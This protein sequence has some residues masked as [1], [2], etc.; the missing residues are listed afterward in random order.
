MD[1][2][3]VP[4]ATKMDALSA[5]AVDR[6]GAFVQLNAEAAVDDYRLLQQMNEA[7]RGRYGEMNVV[8]DRIRK[9]G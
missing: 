4:D 7:T 6:L 1:A 5:N 8:G 2:V 9:W 3:D